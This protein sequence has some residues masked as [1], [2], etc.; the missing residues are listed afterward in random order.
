MKKTILKKLYS[1]KPGVSLSYI[2]YELWDRCTFFVVGLRTI[3]WNGIIVEMSTDNSVSMLYFDVCGR[4][5]SGKHYSNMLITW[6]N[7]TRIR[8]MELQLFMCWNEA[9]EISFTIDTKVALETACFSLGFL[10]PL[11]IFNFYY[12]NDLS[13]QI[14]N[15]F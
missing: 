15:C 13:K 8:F 14:G 9:F 6:T 10:F 5:K 3:A 2:A 12:F 7:S 1:Q 4:K 11:Q